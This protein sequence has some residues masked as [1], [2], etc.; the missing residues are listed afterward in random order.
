M[1]SKFTY[2]FYDNSSELIMTDTLSINFAFNTNST[3]I[4]LQTSG[5]EQ[6]K[7]LWKAF[8]RKNG[9]KITFDN[10]TIDEIYFN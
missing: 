1:L 9:I 7:E 6:A 4:V 8:A 5:G 3:T 2:S 10:S